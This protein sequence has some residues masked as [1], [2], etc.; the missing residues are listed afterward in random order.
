[1]PKKIETTK[2]RFDAV[3]LDTHDNPEHSPEHTARW[4][5]EDN[6]HGAQ[7]MARN[8]R[9]LLLSMSLKHVSTGIQGIA[10]MLLIARLLQVRRPPA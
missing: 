6:E 8:S 5:L 2:S 10:L 1:M 7:E 4:M 9:V 3:K